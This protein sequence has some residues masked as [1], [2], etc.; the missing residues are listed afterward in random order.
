MLYTCK[1]CGKQFSDSPSSKRKCC[2]RTCAG[3]WRSEHRLSELQA[4]RIKESNHNRIWKESSRKKSSETLKRKG[5]RPPS[6]KGKPHFTFRG[7]KNPRWKGGITPENKRIRMSL[8]YRLWRKAIFERDNFTCQKCGQRGGRLRAHHI[9]NF[10][11]YPENR[12]EI[13]NGITLCQKCHN[14]FHRIYGKH[15]NTKEQLE[16]FMGA[17]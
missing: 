5:I 10:A 12:T 1:Q 11:D 6:Q 16:V 17:P 4:Q 8:E 2:S 9:F 3:K 13:S 7:A 14:K 15:N